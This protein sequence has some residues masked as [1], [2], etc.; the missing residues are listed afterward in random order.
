MRSDLPPLARAEWQGAP[1]ATGFEPLDAGGRVWLYA[2]C[3]DTG[4]LAR[5]ASVCEPSGQWW[6]SN[7]GLTHVCGRTVWHYVWRERLGEVLRARA[8]CEGLGV[9][10]AW[11]V[12]GCARAL[13]RWALGEGVPCPHVGSYVRDRWHYYGVRVGEYAEVYL[14]DIDSA[15]WQLLGRL[16]TPLPLL[17]RDG[18]VLWQEPSSEQWARWSALLASVSGC[19]LLRNALVGVSLAGLEPSGYWHAGELRVVCGRVGG[20]ACLG[21][22]VVRA[23]YELTGWAY[24]T[25]RGAVYA[26]TDCVIASQSSPPAVWESAGLRCSLRASGAGVVRGV[27]AYRVGDYCTGHFGRV[28]G[29]GLAVDVAGAWREDVARA[30]LAWLL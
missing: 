4:T 10:P 13:L 24:H 28:G 17:L 11:S 23:C 25:T 30:V 1:L 16:R 5:G 9:E 12:G 6:A 27:G 29:A 19:K 22:L 21:G 20:H 15:Y 2:S 18:Q 26:N 14:W 3:W 7:D 8:V